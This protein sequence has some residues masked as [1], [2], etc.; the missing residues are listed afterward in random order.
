MPTAPGRIL[1]SLGRRRRLNNSY[2]TQLSYG[3]WAYVSSFMG[4]EGKQGS[5]AICI[6]ALLCG[7]IIEN[8]KSEM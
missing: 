3:S 1:G 6:W 7:T 5:S 4:R 8:Y 2:P